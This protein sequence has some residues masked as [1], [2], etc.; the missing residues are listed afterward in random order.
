ME[1]VCFNRLG[2]LR[3]EKWVSCSEG[4]QLAEF[5]GRVL[6]VFNGI[7]LQ[8]NLRFWPEVERVLVMGMG[9]DERR[10]E[11]EREKMQNVQLS[12]LNFQRPI[13]F[14]LKVGS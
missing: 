12:T 1:R 8:K 3:S 13:I 7:N 6:V 4:A 2:R 14:T 10:R 9:C 11:G 5:A